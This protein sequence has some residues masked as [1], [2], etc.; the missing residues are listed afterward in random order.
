M[1]KLIYENE[2]YIM[3]LNTRKEYELKVNDKNSER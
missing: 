2:D 1:Q 3:S